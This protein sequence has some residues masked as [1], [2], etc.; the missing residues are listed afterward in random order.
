M[1]IK[2]TIY[3][4]FK[5]QVQMQPTAL[6]V[7]DSNRRLT[8]RELDR[9]VNAIAVSFTMQ[10]QFVGVVMNHSVE[11]V[12]SLLAVLKTGAAYVPVEPFFPEKRMHFIM[13]ECKV[14]FIITEQQYANKLQGFPLL[15]VEQGI[16]AEN[17]QPE[18]EDKSLPQDIAYVLYTSGST[19]LPKGVMVENRNV[20]HYVRAF[21]NEFH[22]TTNDVM[23]QYSVCSFDIFVEEVFTTLLSGATLAIP[24]E[25]E[26]KD[27]Q[28]LMRFVERNGVTIISGFPYLLLEMN[29]LK[30]IPASLRLLISGG[31]VLRTNF[32][33]NLLPQ[34]EIYNTYGPSETTV[35]ASYFR[36]NDTQPLPDG[37]YP[38]G[39]AIKGTRIQIL[40]ENLKPVSAGEVGEICIS[41]KGVSRG[42]IGKR[43]NEA[44]ITQKNGTT[45]YRSGD[46]GVLQADGNIQFLRR[47]D[48][49][50]M[51]MGKRVEPF[52][53][54]SILC[55]CNEVESGV[56]R[57]CTD[58]R[59]LSYLTAYIVPKDKKAFRIMAVKKAMA[60]YLPVYM[61]PEFFVRMDAMPITPNGKINIKA[62]PI[63]MKTCCS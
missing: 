14:D 8:F 16:K 13:Q 25:D 48:T 49:Q 21:E 22:P 57:P 61:I 12:A 44:F 7:F 41:G 54:Q 2:N 26:K 59:G 56:I 31:D 23:L 33:S 32:I 42:Y 36:C 28:L 20:C 40:D 37:T 35:C 63:V 45:I 47:K 24:Q 5:K 1:E 30:N 38:I 46:L 34:V 39:R 27:V 15:F 9:L 62:L 3:G 17:W 11:M 19:G 4:N 53:V 52:E 50:V 18:I 60:K 10:P 29:K 55:G 6:A 58:E 43:E 51:I